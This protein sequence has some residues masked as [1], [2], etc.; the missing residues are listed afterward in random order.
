MATWAGFPEDRVAF[1]GAA[2]ADHASSP[3]VRRTFCPTCGTPLA[4]RG[5]RWP[6]EVHLL[7]A[8]FDAPEDLPP[9]AHVNVGEKLPWV[10]LSDGLRRFRT[11]G[12]DGPPEDPAAAP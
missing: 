10:H 12:G 6:G 1:A 2:P 7:V 5:G 8:T 3:G 9:R 11:T 4:Y